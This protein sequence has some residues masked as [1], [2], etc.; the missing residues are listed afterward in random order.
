MLNS[1]FNAFAAHPSLDLYPEPLRPAIDAA[2]ESFYASIN[3]GVYRCG[4][5]TSQG[6]YDAAVK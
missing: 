6:A 4:F 3:N 2:N 1:E 5:A